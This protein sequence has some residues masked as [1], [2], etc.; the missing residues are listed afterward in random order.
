MQSQD[1]PVPEMPGYMPMRLARAYVPPQVYTTRWDPAE[2]LRR[3]TIF[4]ELYMPY[5]QDYAPPVRPWEA[6]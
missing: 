1:M 4:P 3:G 5:M 2:G 6:T